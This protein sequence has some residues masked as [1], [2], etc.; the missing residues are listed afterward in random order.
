MSSQIYQLSLV[1][2]VALLLAVCIILF[3]LI[4]IIQR[5]YAFLKYLTSRGNKNDVQQKSTE[6]QTNQESSTYRQ[7]E[8]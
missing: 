6:V 5:I 4:V 2:T 8:E 1:T 3:I 7:K